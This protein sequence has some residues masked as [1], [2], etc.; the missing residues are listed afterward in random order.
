M[1]ATGF[2]NDRVAVVTGAGSGIGLAIA[3]RFAAEGAAVV[4]LDINPT[5]GQAAASGIQARSG[6]CEFV[7]AD[8]SKEEDVARAITFCAERYGGIDHIVNNAGIVLVKSIEECTVEEWDR[9]MAVNVR[10]IFLTA[11]YGLPWLRRS[12]SSTIVN[13]GSV[14]S[15]VGQANTPAYVASKGAVALLSKTMALDFAK[16]GI[17]VNCICPGI[18]DTPMLRSHISCSADPE[19]TIR[20]RLNRVPLA[21]MLTGDDIASAAL[22]LS[23]V[24]SS[25][26]TGATLLVDA[27]YLAAAEWSN[28]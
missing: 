17:R 28:S 12:G 10:S 4:A 2:F 7:V 21:R 26:I 1:S 22:Y 25:G 13:I 6:R 23:S 8:V 27:G 20:E 11:K 14:S 19:K 18:T 9:V 24:E 3:N 5:T 16:C 15:F